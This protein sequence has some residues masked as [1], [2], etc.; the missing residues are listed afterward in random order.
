MHVPALYAHLNQLRY[1]S[2]LLSRFSHYIF[3]LQKIG[4]CLYDIYLSHR[5]FPRGIDDSYFLIK[6]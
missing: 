1:N 2:F 3:F 6:S 5:E 4:Q